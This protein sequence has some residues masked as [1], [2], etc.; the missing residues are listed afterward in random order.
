MTSL[1]EIVKRTMPPSLKAKLIAARAKLAAPPLE[2]IVLHPYTLQPDANAKPRLTLVI[3][4]LAPAKTFG[5][6]A[7]GLDIFMAVA[8]HAGLTPRIVIDDFDRDVDQVLIAK[9]AHHYGL[10][11]AD[12]IVTLR[13]SENQPLNVGKDDLFVAYN[14]WTATNLAPLIAAQQKL[15]GG[16]RK[17]LIYLFQEYEPA[18]YPMSSTLL[19]A[20]APLESDQPTW[21]VFNSSQIHA[22]FRALG[23]RLE[24]EYLFE[25][26]LPVALRPFIG[27]FGQGK[28]PIKE[29]LILIYGRPDT[30]RNCFPAIVQ[31]L[32]LWTESDLQATK[33]RIESAGVAHP[34]ITLAG[35]QKILS[36]GKLSLEAYAETLQRAAI[37][38]S[39]MASA[40]PSYPPLEMAHF[41][42]RTLTNRFSNKDLSLAH[43]N[44]TSL[45]DIAP[46]TIAAALSAAC[47]AFEAA[48]QAGWTGRSHMPN[49]LTNGPYP[50]LNALTEDL[51]TALA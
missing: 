49:Y 40:H 32:K 35:E 31:G 3:P 15:Y 48:P 28:Q 6:V 13:T 39:L 20:R 26:Q 4:T 27:P 17:P 30:P 41:G 24:R 22:Y 25:P 34:P 45:P 46:T 10:T 21:G 37:G 1:R 2:Q 50:F 16:A 19:F 44:I 29:R 51:K 5:G 36:R 7:T 33:W 11:P 12:V 38:V 47:A 14:W 8:A 23:H 42:A 9:C 18:F 43:D